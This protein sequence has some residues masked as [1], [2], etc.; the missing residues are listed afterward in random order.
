MR[1]CG[2]TTGAKCGKSAVQIPALTTLHRRC[3][4][5]SMTAP[6]PILAGGQRP[7]EVPSAILG[8]RCLAFFI[9][10]CTII[11][12]HG[13]GGGSYTPCYSGGA[14]THLQEPS[15]TGSYFFMR[16]SALAKIHRLP[17]G[18]CALRLRLGCGNKCRMYPCRRCD[19]PAP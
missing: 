4:I 15:I 9:D 8:G 7:G 17:L 16:F 11:L 14:S 10:T 13:C 3:I 5:I 18:L 1:E 2:I 12:Y 6:L 19:Q